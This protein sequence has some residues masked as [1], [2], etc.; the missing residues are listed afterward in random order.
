MESEFDAFNGHYKLLIRQ[1]VELF[2]G[3]FHT[4][5]HRFN[6]TTQKWDTYIHSNHIPQCYYSVELRDRVDNVHKPLC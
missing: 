2:S 4:A 3:S 5:T 6:Q 1:N